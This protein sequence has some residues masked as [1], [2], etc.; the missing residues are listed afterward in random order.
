MRAALAASMV[1]A[2]GAAPRAALAVEGFVG[3]RPLAMANSGR[4]WALGD[5]GLLLNPAGMSLTKAYTVEG[6]Y[7]YGSAAGGTHFAHASIVD[8][9]RSGSG[10]YQ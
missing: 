1:I 6:S 2:L 4:A 7:V 5:S 9:S 8:S 3:T 10:S